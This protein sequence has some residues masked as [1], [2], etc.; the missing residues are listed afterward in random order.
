MLPGMA[1]TTKT[2][3]ESWARR[4]ERWTRSGLTAAEF[5]VREGF[6]GK[7]LSWWK[8]HLS[9]RT[10]GGSVPARRDGAARRTP[11]LRF[12]PARVVEGARARARAVGAGGRVE[13][14]LGNGRVVR[15]AGAVDDAVLIQ[16]LRVADIDGA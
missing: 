11:P 4:V 9:R 15:V 5:G 3:A 8:W 7:Q 16:A 10:T 2:T 12:V 6:E 13:I 1:K 14:V